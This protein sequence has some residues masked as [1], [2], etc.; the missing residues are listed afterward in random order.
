MLTD[1]SPASVTDRFLALRAFENLFLW[2]TQSKRNKRK[3]W[4]NSALIFVDS[5]I[6]PTAVSHLFCFVCGC[7]VFVQVWWIILQLIPIKRWPMK[8]PPTFVFIVVWLKTR[9]WWLC[10]WLQVMLH[11][12][13]EPLP[14]FWGVHILMWA[15]L[16]SVVI[17]MR[18]WVKK[19]HSSCA[20]SFAGCR[21]AF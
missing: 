7:L 16:Y 12:S 19:V 14:Q 21:I 17:A 1:V 5:W 15:A 2:N 20:F 9:L 10:R 18:T 4:L 8:H 6:R 3:Y 11:I 13:S